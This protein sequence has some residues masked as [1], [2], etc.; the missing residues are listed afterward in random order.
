[1]RPQELEADGDE[2]GHGDQRDQPGGGVAHAQ[3]ARIIG[4]PKSAALAIE[5]RRREPEVE[6]GPEAEDEPDRGGDGERD[7]KAGSVHAFEGQD[8]GVR[9]PAG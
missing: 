2:G 9:G 5:E 7:H 6:I 1:M 4:A 3:V 8:G